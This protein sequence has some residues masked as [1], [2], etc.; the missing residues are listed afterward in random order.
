[1]KIGLA[2]GG[3][4][5]RGLAHISLLRVLEEEGIVPT[6]ISGSS[7]GALVGACIACG[8]NS[9]QLRNQ[10]ENHVFLPEKGISEFWRKGKDLSQWLK[11]FRPT[12]EKGAFLSADGFLSFLLQDL[13]TT[14]FEELLTPFY[15][16]A[17][18]FQT[19]NKVV[20]S[21]GPLLPALKAS[22]AIPGVFEPVRHQGRL[23][24]DGGVAD[25]VPWSTLDASCDAVIAIDVAGTNEDTELEPDA[26]STFVSI[27]QRMIARQTIQRRAIDPPVLYFKPKL[28]NI[29]GLDF[30]RIP[31]VFA[32]AEAETERF[33]AELKRH[34]PQLTR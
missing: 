19:C 5:V 21:E 1:M 10:V 34:F 8:R 17:A 6:A 12:I 14:N 20:F 28:S 30:A 7:M 11:F 4:G 2:L 25:N 9:E 16:V 32:Q 26:I 18:D 33:R 27:F 23:L 13:E 3:G 29:R 22:M 15:A 31:E 24:V